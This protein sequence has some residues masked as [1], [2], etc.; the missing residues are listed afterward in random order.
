MCQRKKQAAGSLQK[1]PRAKDDKNAG[2]LLTLRRR[3]EGYGKGVMKNL[4][5]VHVR[6][7]PDIFN[8]I[9]ACDDSV[10]SGE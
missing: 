2:A 4:H 6:H 5:Q 10:N 3:V 1:S 9:A 7:A 8:I